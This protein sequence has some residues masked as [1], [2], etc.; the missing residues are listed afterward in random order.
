MNTTHPPENTEILVV[1]KLPLETKILHFIIPCIIAH[2]NRNKVTSGNPTFS[3]P[4]ESSLTL[5]HSLTT[6]SKISTPFARNGVEQRK[7]IIVTAM[8]ERA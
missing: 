2:V 5:L 4:Q 7:G 1:N 6:H 3:A 8:L